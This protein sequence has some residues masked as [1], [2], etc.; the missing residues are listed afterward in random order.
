MNTNINSKDLNLLKIFLV[1]AEELNLTQAS[2]RLGLSQPA[3]SH[4]LQRLRDEFEDP[5]FVRG[6]RGLVATPRVQRMVPQI[7]EILSLS[8]SLYR[9]P[10]LDDF[11][12]LERN[13]VLGATT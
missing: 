6:S 9:G 7:R 12:A 11:R 3:L 4:S 2:K 5:L 8:E 13:F 10:A 1:V